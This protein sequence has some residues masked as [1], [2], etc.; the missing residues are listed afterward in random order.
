M[1]NKLIFT[2]ILLIFLLFNVS[3]NKVQE[4]EVVE[5]GNLVN[6]CSLAG[7]PEKYESK[8]IETKAIVL[9]YHSFI[10]YSGECIEQNKIIAL[11]MSYESRYKI[12][13]AISLNK[14]NYH[15]DYLNNNVYAE[16]FAS[17]ELK[18]NVEKEEE[19][20]FHPKFKFF[21]N[22]IKDIKILTEE[23]LPTEEWKNN[24]TIK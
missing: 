20:V 5:S 6:F 14:I 22:E 19:E 3:C 10:F 16:I 11:D 4:K 1:K 13:E 17:G 21:V 15:T 2:S 12:L 7:S 23:I 24:K 9:G 8:S 18:K